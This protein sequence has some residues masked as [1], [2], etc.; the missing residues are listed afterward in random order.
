MHAIHDFNC[1]NG[2]YGLVYDVEPLNFELVRDY[3]V[4]VNPN[5]SYYTNLREHC[6]P[7]TE[8]SIIG[9]EGLAPDIETLETIRFH[10]SDRLKYRGILYCTP[11]PLDLIRFQLK[12][13]IS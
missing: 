11:Q 5:F 1:G 7:H 10:N 9:V 8:E 4:Q 12:E 2:L 3:L 6:N 13:I